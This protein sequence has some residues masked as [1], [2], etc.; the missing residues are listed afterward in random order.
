MLATLRR[1]RVLRG[2]GLRKRREASSPLLEAADD[3]REI[4]GVNSQVIVPRQS[5][6]T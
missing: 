5:Q 1:H 4:H 2:A 6:L 3:R